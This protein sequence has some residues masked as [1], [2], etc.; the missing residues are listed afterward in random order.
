[1]KREPITLNDLT[2]IGAQIA[3][4]EG[5]Y[6]DDNLD[7]L[8]EQEAEARNERALSGEDRYD[9]EAQADLAFHDWLWPYGYGRFE[10]EESE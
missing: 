5:W 10:P 4:Y 9:P 3:S 7:A 2:W 6:S 1:M 8:A